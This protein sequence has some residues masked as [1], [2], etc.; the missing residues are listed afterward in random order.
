MKTVKDVANA[1]IRLN[2]RSSVSDVAGALEAV[3]HFQG[4]VRDFKQTLAADMISWIKKNG[5]FRMGN[6]RY[7]VGRKKRVKVRDGATALGSLCES[8]GGDVD[9]VAGLMSAQPW[10][11]GAVK[12]EIGEDKFAELFE[13]IFEDDL[14]T[15]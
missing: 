3:I 13:E 15:G 10:K 8:T 11:H 4:L 9:A 14:K 5:D 6:I 12:K 2:D 7:S 1:L